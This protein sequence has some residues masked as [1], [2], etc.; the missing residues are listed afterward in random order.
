MRNTKT[1]HA[2]SAPMLALLALLLFGATTITAAPGDL[3]PTFGIGGR[4]IDGGVFANDVGDKSGGKMVVVGGLFAILVVAR[5]NPNGSPD[6][7][8]GFGNE[9]VITDLGRQKYE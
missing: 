6:V 7:T 3:D 1:Y 8:F 5:Y 9:K 4:L 2:I